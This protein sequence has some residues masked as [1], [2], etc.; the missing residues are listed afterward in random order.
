LTNRIIDLASYGMANPKMMAWIESNGLDPNLIPLESTAVIDGNELTV[1]EWL[2][3]QTV[4]GAPPH[5]TLADDH[6]G[7]KRTRRTV[8]L[9]SAPEDHGL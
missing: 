8:P 3:E 7:Y 1:T 4:P 9:L 5:K 2:L 6:S